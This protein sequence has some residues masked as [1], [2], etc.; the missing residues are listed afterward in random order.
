MLA[1]NFHHRFIY[2]FQQK[3]DIKNIYRKTNQYKKTVKYQIILKNINK[4]HKMFII[5][6]QS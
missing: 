5:I 4:M 3:K 6:D 1:K 2:H